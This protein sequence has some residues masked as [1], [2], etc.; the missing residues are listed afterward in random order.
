MKLELTRREFLQ[1]A[2]ALVVAFGLPAE[3]PAQIKLLWHCKI[4]TPVHA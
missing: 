2:G 3:L 4:N 1:S